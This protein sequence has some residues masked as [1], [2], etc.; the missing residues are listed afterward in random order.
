MPGHNSIEENEEGHDVG[1]LKA[2]TPF[3]GL[4]SFSSPSN[5]HIKEQFRNWSNTS[6]SHTSKEVYQSLTK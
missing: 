2:K 1:K 4:K 3:L 6:I 5:S